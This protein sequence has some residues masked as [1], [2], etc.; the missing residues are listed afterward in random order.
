MKYKTFIGC[1]VSKN[2]SVTFEEFI[3]KLELDYGVEEIWDNSNWDPPKEYINEMGEHLITRIVI[4]KELLTIEDIAR[5]KKYLMREEERTSENSKRKL[6]LNPGY[7]SAKGMYFLTHKPNESRR[8]I[9]IT[10]GIWQEKQYDLD[11]KF[12]PNNNTFFE[13]L[14]TERLELFNNLYK[15]QSV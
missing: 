7:L 3:S 12:I 15:A 1:L 9:K 6:N 2:N 5:L 4:L 14:S 13:Y 10:E 11:E 8:R